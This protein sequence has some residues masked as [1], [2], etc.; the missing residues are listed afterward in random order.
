MKMLDRI[1]IPL[2]AAAVLTGCSS[3]NYEKGSATGAGLQASADKVTEGSGK[4]DTALK[5]LNDMVNTPGDLPT[6]FKTYSASV[7][8]LESSVSDVQTKVA[9]MRAKGNEYF[10]A[11]D[12]QTAQI[13]NEDIKNRSAQRKAELQQKFTEIKMSYT[14]ASSGFKPFVSDL[15]DIQ[16]ALATDLTPAGVNSIKGAAEKAN[17]DS[18]PLK[19]SMAKLAG[20]FKDLGASMQ[21]VAAKAQAAQGQK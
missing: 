8:D 9:D 4:I 19:A 15:K 12:A 20:Q 16:T 13:K 6:Q 10:K 2:V 7:S 18:V 21:A 11:W 5:A 14:E 17:K 3:A 1:V